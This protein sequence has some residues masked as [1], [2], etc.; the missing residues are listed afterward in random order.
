MNLLKDG[1]ESDYQMA[2]TKY[3]NEINDLEMKRRSCEGII[4][5]YNLGKGQDVPLP[6]FRTAVKTVQG[7]IKRFDYL[8]DQEVGIS[9][10]SSYYT[11]ELSSMR[12]LKDTLAT[13][14]RMFYKHRIVFF[15]DGRENEQYVHAISNHADTHR[16]KF[17]LDNDG[18][19]HYEE[20][21]FIVSGNPYVEDETY[22]LHDFEVKSYHSLIDP[23][24]T[25]GFLL[26]KNVVN[27]FKYRGEW[28]VFREDEINDIVHF[29]SMQ[30]YPSPFSFDTTRIHVNGNYIVERCDNNSLRV[31]LANQ[32]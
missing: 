13:G 29:P 31:Y 10:T 16:G 32:S 4:E 1:W 28:Y 7:S 5:K 22:K 14:S 6:N 25:I 26:H 11:L 2:T 30:F 17:F 23:N 24:D 15:G 12:F 8:N 27:P 21:D 9:T 3:H 18:K 20:V 19:L